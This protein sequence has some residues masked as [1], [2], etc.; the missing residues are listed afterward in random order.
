MIGFIGLG[1]GL[2]SLGERAW[3]NGFMIHWFMQ[4]R[5]WL[6][7]SGALLVITKHTDYN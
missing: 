6:N 3:F 2:G 4:Q 5:D 1:M 7:G